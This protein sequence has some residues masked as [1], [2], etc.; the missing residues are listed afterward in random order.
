MMIHGRL[1]LQRAA[2]IR[3]IFDGTMMDMATVVNMAMA[4][5]TGRRHLNFPLVYTTLP[6]RANTAFVMT[7]V[8]I[9]HLISSASR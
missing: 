3:L 7:G 9:H 8:R 6:G 2:T 5:T 1:L 4:M